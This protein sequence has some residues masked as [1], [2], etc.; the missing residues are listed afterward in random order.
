MYRHNVVVVSSLLFVK[1]DRDLGLG[2]WEQTYSDLHS[3]ICLKPELFPG[4]KHHAHMPF[5]DAARP[6]CS[7]N[8]SRSDT[9]DLR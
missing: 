9:T 4:A 6:Q 5:Y 7:P 3:L 8:L 1:A 2:V